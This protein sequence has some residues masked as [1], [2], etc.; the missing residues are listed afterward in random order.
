MPRIILS[1]NAGSSSVKVSVYEAKGNSDTPNQL[2]EAQVEGL[3]APPTRLKYERGDEKIKGKELDGINT[4]ED[5]FR[6]IL[7]Y[8]TKDSGLPQLNQK[9][10]IKFTCHRVVH[11][12]D[13]PEAQIIDE[14]TYHHIETLSDLAPL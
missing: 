4:Q 3:T 1:I 11:G 8:L 6:Y 7:D 14:D 2:A 13:Y 10:D 9:E 12:G 5:S